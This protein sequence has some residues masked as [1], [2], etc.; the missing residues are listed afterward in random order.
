MKRKKQTKRRI[1]EINTT[2]KSSRIR[3]GKGVK[4]PYYSALRVLGRRNREFEPVKKLSN[5]KHGGMNKRQ[6]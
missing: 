4:Q 3:G 2:E 5:R 6:I 1:K